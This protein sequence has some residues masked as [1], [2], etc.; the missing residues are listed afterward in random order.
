[1]SKMP[2]YVKPEDRDSRA[3]YPMDNLE[4]IAYDNMKQ[5]QK[6]ALKGQAA[7][8]AVTKLLG[9]ELLPEEKMLVEKEGYTP[10]YYLDSKDIITTGVGQTGDY[11]QTPFDEVMGTELTKVQREIP[12]Y[13]DASEKLQ[14]DMF[15]EAYRGSLTQE[16]SPLTLEL[17]KKGLFSEAADEYLRNEEYDDAVAANSG[18]AGRMEALAR[19]LRSE[20]GEE[21]WMDGIN[22]LG[23]EATKGFKDTFRPAKRAYEDFTEGASDLYESAKDKASDLFGGV[24]QQS[25]GGFDE[26]SPTRFAGHI[27]YEN[28]MTLDELQSLNPEVEITRGSMGRALQSGQKLR[29]GNSWYEN[30]A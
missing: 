2:K 16:N 6:K 19:S 8:Q 1:M 5:S 23:R 9:R 17:I 30:L 26:I 25:S 10:D 3:F 4:R 22:Q 27:A 15:S 14:M 28:G 29:V 21:S 7:V 11:T 20:G 24:E 18:V 13:V 12:Y